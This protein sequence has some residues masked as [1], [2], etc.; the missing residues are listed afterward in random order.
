MFSDADI[1]SINKKLDAISDFLSRLVIDV[2]EIRQRVTEISNPKPEEPVTEKLPLELPL[3]TITELEQLEE[4][5]KSDTGTILNFVSCILCYRS[6]CI[7][8]KHYFVNFTMC[9]NCF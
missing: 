9:K 2:T 5:I 3:K 7:S 8:R 6:R 1:T 4:Y